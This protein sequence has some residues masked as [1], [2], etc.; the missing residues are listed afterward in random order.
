M[1]KDKYNLTLKSGSCNGFLI[2]FAIVFLWEKHSYFNSLFFDLIVSVYKKSIFCVI[3]NF[4]LTQEVGYF[5]FEITRASRA[6]RPMFH[7]R[8]GMCFF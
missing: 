5:C 6:Q 4:G 2:F 8:V 1:K 3:N 7:V